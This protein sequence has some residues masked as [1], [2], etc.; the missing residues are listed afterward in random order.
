MAILLFLFCG[1]LV[2]G[3]MILAGR[4]FSQSEAA[5]LIGE[6]FLLATGGRRTHPAQGDDGR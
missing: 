5:P 3:L 6:A 4:A 2:I 1:G